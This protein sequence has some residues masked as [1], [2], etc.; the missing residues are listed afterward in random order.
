MRASDLVMG[1]AWAITPEALNNILAIAER[2]N[3]V[4]PEALEAYRAEH[5]PTAERLQMRDGVAILSVSGPLFR[6][7]NLFTAISGA[8]S[9]DVLRLDF[10]VAVDDAEARAILLNFDTPG[11]HAN[12]VNEMAKAIRDARGR[13]P[14]VAYVGGMAASAGYWMAS[15]ADRIVIDETASLGSIGVRAA[16]PAQRDDG[17]VEFVSSQSPG[18]RL[19]LTS[20]DGRARIQARIN[21]LADVFIASVASGRGVTAEH[22]IARFGAGDVLVGASA[23][24]A[25]M[26]DEFGTFES[27][28]ADLAATPAKSQPTSQK[29]RLE[30]VRHRGA[31][32]DAA[33]GLWDT[34]QA[35]GVDAAIYAGGHQTQQQTGAI[36]MSTNPAPANNS[37]SVSDEKIDALWAAALARN[38]ERAGIDE[39]AAV[40][41]ATPQHPARAEGSGAPLVF[42]AGGDLPSAQKAKVDEMWA[43]AI[44]DINAKRDM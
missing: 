43:K 2:R 19:D 15:Q 42:S 39:P 14:I 27:V 6:H 10:Q 9:Y 37:G 12:G 20:D 30:L 21:A 34:M 5:V 31:L 11:G 41:P 25:G 44:A 8:T 29:P 38:S 3:E 33:D 26:A 36:H 7:A 28:L 1:E 18:K 24:T 16:F 23:I 4:T 35:E 22:V 13:K 32:V 17:S 40:Q